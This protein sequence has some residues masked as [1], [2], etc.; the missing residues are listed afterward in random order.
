[1]QLQWK[2]SLHAVPI[3]DAR[4]HIPE[5][6]TAGPSSNHPMITR[7][8][9]NIFKPKT[10]HDDIIKYPLSGALIVEN[11]HI[12]QEPTCY[13]EAIKHPHWREVMSREF[14]ALLRNGTWSLV[15]S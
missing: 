3:S 7:A 5:A 6:T 4:P 11:S 13:I 9:D 1:M 10:H 15:T 8:R 14:D 2:T 12:T